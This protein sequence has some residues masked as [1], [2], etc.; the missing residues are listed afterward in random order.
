MKDMK[1]KIINLS[2]LETSSQIKSENRNDCLL[3]WNL[4]LI[5]NCF[6]TNNKNLNHSLITFLFIDFYLID[7]KILIQSIRYNQK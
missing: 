1:K 3:F 7:Y 2:R 5:N 4:W 6:E